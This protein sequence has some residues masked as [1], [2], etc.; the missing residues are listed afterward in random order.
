MAAE[1]IEGNGD[2]V[3]IQVKVNLSGTMLEAEERI[4]KACSEAGMLVSA[5]ALKRLE[6]DGLPVVV[7][8][9]KSSKRCA[10][11]KT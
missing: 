3:T 5:E 8:A 2:E 6:N 11:P 10:S 9:I 7:G 1:L 4:Q